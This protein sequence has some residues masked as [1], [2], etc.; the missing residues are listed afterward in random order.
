MVKLRRQQAYTPG[1]PLFKASRAF[2]PP[3]NIAP[4][5]LADAYEMVSGEPV[6]V[7]EYEP[8]ISTVHGIFTDHKGVKIP[9]KWRDDGVSLGTRQGEFTRALQVRADFLEAYRAFVMGLQ[10]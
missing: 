9:A 4:A 3:K 1:Q 8:E 10:D 5:M 7:T 2:L 6:T